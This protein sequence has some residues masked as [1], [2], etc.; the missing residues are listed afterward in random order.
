MFMSESLWFMSPLRSVC[1][2]WFSHDKRCN[3]VEQFCMVQYLAAVNS[4]WLPD[5]SS[6]SRRHR[7]QLAPDNRL[8]RRSTTDNKIQFNEWLKLRWIDPLMVYS[9]RLP[10]VQCMW[11]NAKHAHVLTKSSDAIWYYVFG[12]TVPLLADWMYDHH[13]WRLETDPKTKCTGSQNWIC[14]K[15]QFEIFCLISISTSQRNLD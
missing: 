6:W 10:H 12:P 2:V 5:S 13:S 14:L 15:R 3:D 1:L 9:G 4:N 11:R 8:Y 7:F